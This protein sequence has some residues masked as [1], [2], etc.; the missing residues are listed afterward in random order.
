MGA[1]PSKSS[2]L[3]MR[4]SCGHHLTDRWFK[5]GDFRSNI[6]TMR[7]LPLNSLRAFAAV[8]SHRGV[9][10]AGRE[11]RIAHSSVSR[12]LAELEGWLG[13]ALTQKGGG[14][15]GLA[16]TPQG[17]ALG[18]A[19][20]AG[21]GGIAAVATSLR[22]AR[23]VGSVLVG[24]PPSFAVR[25]LLPRLPRFE[26]A[27]P[28]IEVSVVVDQ[29]LDDL[30]AAGVDLAVRMGRGPFAGTRSTPLADDA[31]YPV[32]SPALWQRSGRPSAPADLVG[33]RLLHDRD[34]YA[35][36]EAW[37]REFGPA[38][39]DVVRGPRFTSTDLVLRA[40]VQ[41]QGVALARHLL[42]ADDLAAGLLVRPIGGLEVGL[43]RAYWIVLPRHLAPR[44]A[45]RTVVDWLEREASAPG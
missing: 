29:R 16:F 36:W 8:Y 25:W 44:P 7:D 43:E 19:V 2:G 14:R 5:D 39:L 40:A 21:L 38:A 18:R 37:R 6:K 26:A 17:E 35:A 32:M 13:V 41:G 12:H 30:E 3:S 31:L 15:R 23:S 4:P 33:L 1:V 24:A 45:T 11:L 34:P 27:H 20:L 42:A 22:E 10:A 9:R 28:E